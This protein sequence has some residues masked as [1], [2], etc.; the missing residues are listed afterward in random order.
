MARARLSLLQ[1]LLSSSCTD[2]MA[3]L[4]RAGEASGDQNSAATWYKLL[5]PLHFV[6]SSRDGPGDGSVGHHLC[7]SGDS[8][9]TAWALL[10]SE[11]TG[12]GTDC[13]SPSSVDVPK[14]Q[15]SHTCYKVLAQSPL[16]HATNI[17]KTGGY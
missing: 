14:E 10:L 8:L 6:Q 2:H 7:P 9:A 12:M 17:P 3:E 5:Q 16:A 11:G 4:W 13:I 15:R 1:T